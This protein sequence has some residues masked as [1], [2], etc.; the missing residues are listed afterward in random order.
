V[1]NPIEPTTK[2]IG[3]V[4]SSSQRCCLFMIVSV[5]GFQAG[6]SRKRSSS[7]HTQSN[8]EDAPTGV[9]AK[10]VR[11]GPTLNKSLSSTEL[12][13]IV[14]RLNDTADDVDNTCAATLSLPTDSAV[15]P[16]STLVPTATVAASTAADAAPVLPFTLLIVHPTAVCADL[17]SMHQAAWI[18][19]FCCYFQVRLI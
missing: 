16:Q 4:S 17:P 11:L 7:S 14:H 9:P 12:T 19:A 3:I 18:D 1:I 10:R 5:S 6:D 13:P 8:S 2:P 15:P